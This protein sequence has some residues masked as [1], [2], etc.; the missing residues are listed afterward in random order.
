M[1]SRLESPQVVQAIFEY[2][3]KLPPKKYKI[4]IW[5]NVLIQYE[6]G[7]LDSVSMINLATFGAEKK[8]TDIEICKMNKEL[9]EMLKMINKGKCDLKDYGLYCEIEVK[10]D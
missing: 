1:S 2:L 7:F 9:F 6:I 3:K 8:Y 5:R 10:L 4:Q